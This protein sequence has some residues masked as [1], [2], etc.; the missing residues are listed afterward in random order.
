MKTMYDSKKAFNSYLKNSNEKQIL[1]DWDEISNLVSI[2]SVLDIG[3]H[4]G[5]LSL[6]LLDRISSNNTSIKMTCVDPSLE[7]IQVFKNKVKERDNFEFY[8][9][10]VEQFISKIDNKKFDLVILSHSLYWSSDIQKVLQTLTKI[11]KYIVI[12]LRG[13]KGIYQIQKEFKHLIGNPNEQLYTSDNIETALLNLKATF[14]KKDIN[15]QITISYEDEDSL[16]QLIYFFLQSSKEKFQE[17]EYQMVK[18][19]LQS[20]KGVIEHNV[21]FFKVNCSET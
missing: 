9:E 10:T 6:K 1:V 3:C 15:S 17:S 16:G 13:K 5:T 12:V 21:T 14:I 20:F 11:S 19:H 2:K 8:N 18:K 4:D 7:A